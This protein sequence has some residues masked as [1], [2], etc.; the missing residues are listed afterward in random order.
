MSFLLINK[1]LDYSLTMPF[2][3]TGNDKRYDGICHRKHENETT[4]T[5]HPFCGKTPC[6]IIKQI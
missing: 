1:E 5:Q 3:C 6:L 2:K 4:P